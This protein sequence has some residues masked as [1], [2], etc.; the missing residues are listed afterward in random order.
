MNLD[1]LDFV[2]KQQNILPCRPQKIVLTLDRRSGVPAQSDSLL[3]TTGP[4][5]YTR[6]SKLQS[7]FVMKL[8]SFFIVEYKNG[9]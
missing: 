7:Y 8:S 2:T 4:I 3:E 9:N 1:I 6:K 5:S